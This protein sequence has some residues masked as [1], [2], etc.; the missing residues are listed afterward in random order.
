MKKYLFFVLAILLALS[1][2]SQLYADITFDVKDNGEIEISG[3]TNYEEFKG[4]TSRLTSKE[5][6]FW[7]LNITGPVFEEFVYEVK[8]PENAVI[9]YIKSNS[10]V[11]I[12]ERLGRIAITASGSNKPIDIKVQYF[13]GKEER[14]TSSFLIISSLIIIALI[15]IGVYYLAKKKIKIIKPAKKDIKRE[16][17]TERQLMILDYLQKKGT[18]TQAQLEKD[19][20]I[21]KASLSRNIQTLAQKGV[22]FKETK[23]MSNVVGFKE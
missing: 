2:Y 19:L 8:L 6:E 9:N 1:A 17:Y 21:P 3:N 22:I 20:K 10:Q 12:E 15:A 18:V 14:S 4:V 13:I 23:G 5:G 16:L 7:F 11:R